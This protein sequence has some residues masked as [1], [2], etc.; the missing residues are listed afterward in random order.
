P[1]SA[2]TSPSRRTDTCDSSRTRSVC[3][4]R[5]LP[6]R[7]LTATG[8]VARLLRDNHVDVATAVILG[9]FVVLRLWATIGSRVFSYPDSP[10]YFDFKLWG[11][12]RFPVVTAK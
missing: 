11:G 9:V 3:S 5:A 2:S 6:E 10:G 8:R 1:A 12:V 4:L 7:S